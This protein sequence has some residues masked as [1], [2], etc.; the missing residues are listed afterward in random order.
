VKKISLLILLLVLFSIGPTPNARAQDGAAAPTRLTLEVTFY[1]GRKPAYETVPGPNAKPS[2]AWF[3]LFARI[4]SAQPV[5]G[6]QEIEA[7]RVVSRVEADGVRV[8]V[9]TL[10]GRK[11]LENEQPV[12][13]Y[14]IHETE[15]IT[16][17]ELRRFGIEPFEIRLLRVNPTIV[18]VPPVRLKGVESV[19]VLN[20]M[21]K[22]TTLPSF[23][24]IL[25]NQSNKNII[26]LG[27]DVVADGK[28]EV[29]SKPRGIE[30]QPLIP[31]GK[32]YWLTVAAPNRAQSTPGGYEPTVPAG[33]EIQIK[34][35]VFD[36]GTYEGEPETA[37]AVR[38]YLAGEKMEL[39]KLISLLGSASNSSNTNV[40]EALRDLESQVSAVGSDADPEI[41]QTLRSEFPKAGSPV[42][43]IIKQGV[44]FSATTI[45]TNLLKE[46]H[47]LQND[48]PQRLNADAYRT[49]LNKTRERYEKWLARL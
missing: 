22:E 37:M 42:S 36:D 38:G 4:N 41:V 43:T 15:K 44:E 46:I 28:V 39:P 48:E 31:T 9:S 12:G 29:T 2:G 49:W 32:E 23:R 3:G 6:A 21:P 8:T 33:I 13:T 26:G 10:S 20:A 40:V 25:R 19:I 1:P 18:P 11:A 47:Q 5:A 30:G 34:A 45:K 7:V 35:A 27:V 17:E 16:V 14:L 24:I